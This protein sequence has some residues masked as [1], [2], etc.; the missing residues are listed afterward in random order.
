MISP[1]SVCQYVSMSVGKCVFS[2]TAHRVFLK[3]LMKLGAVRVKIWLRRIFWEKC[4]FED[5]AQKHPKNFFWILQK[6][7][8]VLMC[9]FFEFRSCT[10]MTFVILLKL[11]VLEKSVSWV[12]CK[13]ALGQSDCRIFKLWYLKDQRRY[14]VDFWHAGT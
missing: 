12:K 2:K 5:N 6:K 4:H 10:I 3:L 9:V 1:L 8:V 7:I 13:N 11:H 14:K